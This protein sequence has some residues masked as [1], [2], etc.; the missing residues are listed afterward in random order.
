MVGYF[1]RSAAEYIS[2]YRS[3]KGVYKPLRAGEWDLMTPGLAYIYGSTES[4]LYL[5]GGIVRGE[6]DSKRL[7][8]RWRAP[9]HRRDLHQQQDTKIL[10]E[11]RFG[12]VVRNKSTE[13]KHRWIHA[14]D[15][16][17]AFAKEYLRILGRDGNRLAV[18]MEGDL[19][20][21]TG[22][23][24][25]QDSTGENLRALQEYYDASG[26]VV[27]QRQI[28]DGGSIKID[29]KASSIEIT[30]NSADTSVELQKLSTNVSTSVNVSAGT[31]MEMK[32][33]ATGR[34]SGSVS[35]LLGPDPV[36][37][38]MAVLGTMFMT[39]VMT[40]F[41]TALVNHFELTAKP[42]PPPGPGPK[43]FDDYKKLAQTLSNQLKVFL[44]LLT[45]TLSLNVKVS[46]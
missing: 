36:P 31:T 24:I 8:S 5:R 41:I 30:E 21:D 42:P 40:P 6:L 44:P 3:G 15:S 43:T 19:F 29:G 9:T 16:D 10:D 45:P 22:T 11:E 7:H 39:T 4:K 12:V 46:K 17:T 27:Y 25:T 37:I 32:A 38:N 20:D 2:R 28:D 26:N 13:E 33:Q 35:T 1:T 18:L 14:P 34:F 23:K